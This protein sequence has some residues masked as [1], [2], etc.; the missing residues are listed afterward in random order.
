MLSKGDADGPNFA[1]GH[2]VADGGQ[3]WPI[4]S[5]DLSSGAADVR[6]SLHSRPSVRGEEP[7][8]TRGDPV[9]A[10]HGGSKGVNL[11]KQSPILRC[12]CRAHRMNG[13]GL[14][15]P[16]RCAPGYQATSWLYCS[17]TR[18]GVSVWWT[19][20]SPLLV[21]PIRI[22]L[23][24]KQK[25]RKAPLWGPQIWVLRKAPVIGNSGAQGLRKEPLGRSQIR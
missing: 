1:L 13:S 12:E 15:C 19:D 25:L 17:L 16:E 5:P 2:S 24:L 3:G 11:D 18:H 23:R 6:T 4:M 21:G 7:H 20:F 10:E 8:P 14:V 22:L 9:G